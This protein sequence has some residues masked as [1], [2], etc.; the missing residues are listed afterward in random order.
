MHVSALQ[1]AYLK[2]RLYA[3]VHFR[4]R[5]VGCRVTQDVGFRVYTSLTVFLAC[6]RHFAVTN[7]SFAKIATANVG[8]ACQ[9]QSVSQRCTRGLW[10]SD[11]LANRI[12]LQPC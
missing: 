11:S 9:K 8:F 12:R 2:K 1:K 4:V 3:D 5:L 6:R 7:A 10:M